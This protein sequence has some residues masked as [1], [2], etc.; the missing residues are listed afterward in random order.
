MF[1]SSIVSFSRFNPKFSPDT[2]KYLQYYEHIVVSKY[3]KYLAVSGENLELNLEK[4]NIDVE[5]VLYYF[6]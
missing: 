5:N 6:F 4:D 2:A 3:F 1:L